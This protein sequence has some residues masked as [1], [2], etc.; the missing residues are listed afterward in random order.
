HLLPATESI[1]NR[2]ETHIRIDVLVL[3]NDILV[4]HT[5]EVLSQ[6]FLTFRRI[7]IV[8][9]GFRYLA[10]S[11]LVYHLVDDRN[12]KLRQQADFWDN[13]IILVRSKNFLS[14]AC[15][16]FKRHQH[17]ANATFGKSRRCSTSACIEDGN[18]LE[19]LSD[20]L[21]Y[22]RLITLER[23]VRVSRRSKISI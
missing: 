12:G 17:V 11:T 4:V 1:F 23:L 22:L 16:S 20:E 5:V 8:Q 10:R 7:E 3:C 6:N 2:H 9:I 19:N 13:D 18:I 15:F 14:P 21:V